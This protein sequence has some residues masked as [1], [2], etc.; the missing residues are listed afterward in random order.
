MAASPTPPQRTFGRKRNQ[1]QRGSFKDGT[2]TDVSAHL[3]PVNAAV[4]TLCSS[5]HVEKRSA[6]RRRE[7]TEKETLLHFQLN[8]KLLRILA[9]FFFFF[10]RGEKTLLDRGLG[11]CVFT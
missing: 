5:P 6:F 11:G 10:L 8:L 2:W 7:R 9:F 3:T 4:V 1:N